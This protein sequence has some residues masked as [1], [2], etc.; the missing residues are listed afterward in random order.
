MLFWGNFIVSGLSGFVI[1]VLWLFEFL[2]L[3]LSPV[4]FASV[5]PGIRVVN[6]I[7]LGYASFAF[8]VTM[9]REIVKDLEDAA[10]DE[11]AGC[12]TLP[13]VA[14]KDTARLIAGA[15][16][17]LNILLLGFI[18]LVL[19]RVNLIFLT[20]YFLLTVQAGALFFLFRLL[21]ARQ[22]KDYHFLSGLCKGIMLAGILSMGIILIS[23]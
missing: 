8:L 13:I 19:F 16:M 20:W 22:K 2:H 6:Y 18:Q 15:M 11:S 17:A 4:D 14:G 23:N 3:R 1:L 12:R 10:G 7:F 21:R 9:V 5:L